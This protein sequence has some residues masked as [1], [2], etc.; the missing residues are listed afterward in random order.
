[1]RKDYQFLIGQRFAMGDDIFEV[2]DL[3]RQD[4]QIYVRAQR[5]MEGGI[6][7]REAGVADDD[8]LFGLAEVIQTLLVDEEIELFSPNYLMAR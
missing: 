7:L 1:M 5:S 2:Q 4:A 8:R 6:V 3:T